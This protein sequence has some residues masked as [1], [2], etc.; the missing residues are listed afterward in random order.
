MSKLRDKLIDYVMSNSIVHNI[1]QEKPYT[2]LE[3]IFKFKGEVF[4]AKGFSKVKWPDNWDDEF[5]YCLACDK[6]V[7]KIAKEI[8][9]D[10]ILTKLILEEN[11]ESQ[12][13][14]PS[15]SL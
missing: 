6:A 11:D 8:M 9:T 3:M 1:I 10:K 2:A 5:G 14:I 12:T 7:A 4:A 13:G 15:N